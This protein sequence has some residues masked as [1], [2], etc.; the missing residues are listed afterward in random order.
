MFLMWTGNEFQAAGPATVSKSCLVRRTTKLPR[1]D[2]R[3]RWYVAICNILY[4]LDV[5][6]EADNVGNYSLVTHCC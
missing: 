2:D 6:V 4:N 5:V 3:R 1:V